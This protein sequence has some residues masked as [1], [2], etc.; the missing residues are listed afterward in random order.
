MGNDNS[1][2]VRFRT[3]A[4]LRPGLLLVTKFMLARM[5]ADSDWNRSADRTHWCQLLGLFDKV[6]SFRVGEELINQVS[7]ALQPGEG[8]SPMELF[9]KLQ[10]LSYSSTGVS[11]A[12][13]PFIK[14]PFQARRNAG[15]GHPVVQVVVETFLIKCN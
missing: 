11:R 9:P 3:Q 8:E 4:F 12:F 10:Q 6:K 2:G 1:S 13:K 14:G 7:R 5:T 15:H